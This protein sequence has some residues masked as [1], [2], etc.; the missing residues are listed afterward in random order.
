MALPIEIGEQRDLLASRS[1]LH[2]VCVFTPN[3][4]SKD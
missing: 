4:C 1:P 2:W 3:A